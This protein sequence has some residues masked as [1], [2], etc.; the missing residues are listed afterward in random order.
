MATASRNIGSHVAMTITNLNSLANSQTAGWQS[1]KVDDT[2]TKALDYEIAVKLTM[3][4]TAPANDKAVYVYAVPWYYDGS[5][6][7]PADCGTGTLPTG[8]EGTITIASPNDMRLLGV[9]NYTT[10]QMVLEGVFSLLNAFGQY[11]PDGWSLV[12]IDYS[13]AA[14]AASANMVAY[15]PIKVD[16]A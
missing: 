9:L 12:I 10:Q 6:W 3:A 1:A 15:K 13:G 8:T 14:I 11:L 2:S 4:N 7:Y 5:S 16:I